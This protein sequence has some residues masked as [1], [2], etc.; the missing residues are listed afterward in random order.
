MMGGLGGLLGSSDSLDLDSYV[1]DKTLDGLFT[2]LAREEAA[3]RQDPVAR[4]T[5]LLQQ[6]FGN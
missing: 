3:I 2:K 5:D 4:S 6:V 1:T